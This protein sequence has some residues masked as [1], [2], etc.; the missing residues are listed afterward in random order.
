MRD[1]SFFCGSHWHI[2]ITQCTLR[3]LSPLPNNWNKKIAQ[4][5]HMLLV[6]FAINRGKIGPEADI[7]EC[8]PFIRRKKKKR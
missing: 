1:T 8:I 3:F 4:S 2:Y 6:S 7:I 5:L